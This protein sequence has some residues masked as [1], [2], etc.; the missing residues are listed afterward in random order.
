[1]ITK[2]FLLV[3]SIKR[4]VSSVKKEIVLA[5]V[6]GELLEAFVLSK[7][8]TFVR[9]VTNSKASE[10]ERKEEKE[11]LDEFQ[12][13]IADGD[14]LARATMITE[15][16]RIAQRTA[17]FAEKSGRFASAKSIVGIDKLVQ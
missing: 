9:I 14:D 13:K 17:T 12:L 2:Q 3:V 16:I 6:K 4:A 5:A 11:K 7:K 8:G 1:M 15:Q 10:D